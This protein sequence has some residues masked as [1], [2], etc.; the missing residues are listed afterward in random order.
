MCSRIPSGAQEHPYDSGVDDPPGG[1]RRRTRAALK[2]LLLDAGIEIL[3]DEGTGV[4]TTSLTYQRVFA[5][6]ESTRGIRVTRGSVHER[7]WAS[8]RDFQLDV[9]RR[10]ARWDPSESNEI[11]LDAISRVLE[12]ADLTTDGGRRLTLKELWRVAGPANLAAAE[13]RDHW[14]SWIG[15]ALA[16]SGSRLDDSEERTALL[17]TVAD[18]YARFTDQQMEVNEAP[19]AL[20]R[21]VPRGDLFPPGFD[22][23]RFL[24]MLATA[25]ADGVALR[26][27]FTD[28]LDDLEL[29]TG[30]DGELETWHPFSVGMWAISSF[31]T[32]LVEQPTEGC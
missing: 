24:T 13:E 9:L 16:L 22:A 25:L 8:Q 3:R 5:H 2:E 26:Q 27:Q 17:S 18:T 21:S 12:T 23:A 1:T 29:A 15:I 19:A 20:V 7:I 30:P 6:L 32:E 28:D 31:L 10:A 4:G 11:T 14:S